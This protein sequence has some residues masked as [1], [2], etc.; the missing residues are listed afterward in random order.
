[1]VPLFRKEGSW[2]VSP[3]GLG[4][5]QPLT[6]MSRGLSPSPPTLTSMKASGL[7]D[8]CSGGK[9]QSYKI[10]WKNSGRTVL[11]FFFRSDLMLKGGNTWKASLSLQ[12]RWFTKNELL[13]VSSGCAIKTSPL[14]QESGDTT[15]QRNN[16]RGKN[17]C[18]VK[19]SIFS[20][21]EEKRNY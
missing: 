15:Q 14:R 3:L 16:R 18:S 21:G 1:M 7:G 8:P 2:P 11:F 13:R 4:S 17:Q 5:K 19:V 10:N 12:Q 6:E 20:S 9:R